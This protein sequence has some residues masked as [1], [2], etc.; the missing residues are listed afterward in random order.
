M[1]TYYVELV[2]DDNDTLLVS[3]PALPEVVSFGED[4]VASENGKLSTL[5]RL[6][7]S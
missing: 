4:G 1:I 2:P 5:S 7:R 3:C 6:Q